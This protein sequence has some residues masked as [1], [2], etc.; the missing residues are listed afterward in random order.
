MDRIIYC[1]DSS[2][3]MQ[4]ATRAYPI[5]VFRSFWLRFEEAIRNGIIIAPDEVLLEVARKDDALHA[6][7]KSHPEM[8]A[9]LAIEVQQAALV[10]TA[11]IPTLVDLKKG[12]GQ[13]DP[14]VV[15]LARTRN[16]TV[17]T[18]ENSKPT[19]PRIPDACRHFGIRC[20]KLL[21][22]IREMQWRF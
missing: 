21:E 19:A 6:W 9:P 3:L 17:V 20:I 14:F 11:E 13:A 18:E 1:F 2:A 16:D 22:F 4:A 8:F 10:V 7:C 12:R 5:E 15:A